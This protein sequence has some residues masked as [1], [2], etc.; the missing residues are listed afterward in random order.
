MAEETFPG[1]PKGHV[2]LI[3]VL[4][5]EGLVQKQEEY[6]ESLRGSVTERH[7]EGPL[8]GDTGK[9]F[10]RMVLWSWVLVKKQMLE[11]GKGLG[12]QGQ[13]RS[14]GKEISSG[15]TSVASA[16]LAQA[17]ATGENLCEAPGDREG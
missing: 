4:G 14:K 1:A 3:W 12:G 13:H 2:V 15:E 17:P 11:M 8:L 9:G 16:N 10:Q 6:T 7:M 5:L